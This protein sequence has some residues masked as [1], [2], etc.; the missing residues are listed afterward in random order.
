MSR[1]TL[2]DRRRAETQ[3][4][5]QAHA[6]P[7]FIERGYEAVTMNEIATAAGVSPMT[8]YRHF[9]TKE[10][11]ILVSPQNELIADRIAAGPSEG[12]L[13][14]RIARALIEA[15]GLITGSRTEGDALL[16][17][18]LR[19]MFTVP[20][21]RARGLDSQQAT[22][23]AIVDALRGDAAPDPEADFHAWA[24]ASA[25][26]AATNVAVMR[27]ATEDGRQDLSELIA[28]A[29]AATFGPDVTGG[30]ST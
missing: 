2:R 18:Q 14:Q 15:S 13:V 22:Q 26:L 29:L 7:L 16:L 19:L 28:A 21:V 4:T 23:H 5:I 9:P 8:L 25:C 17:D 1:P 10:D 6:I 27:W 20:A 30:P 11:L 24:A 3:R 12:T